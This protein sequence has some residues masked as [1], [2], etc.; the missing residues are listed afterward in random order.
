MT[1]Y[2]IIN[3]FV[4]NEEKGFRRT[5]SRTGSDFQVTSFPE[6]V[7][8]RS[9]EE[10]RKQNFAR[11]NLLVEEITFGQ[12]FNSNDVDSDELTTLYLDKI[13][14]MKLIL[15]G[16]LLYAPKNNV[17][18]NKC[19]PNCIATRIHFSDSSVKSLRDL[20]SPIL[21][22]TVSEINLLSEAIVITVYDGYS[23]WCIPGKNI[24]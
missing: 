21:A 10:R 11:Y 19:Q 24:P 6:L 9:L 13:A 15:P 12:I 17:F 4:D 22:L 16:N 23:S 14:A 20:Y 3:S 7:T 2:E 18:D 1:L 8:C 5:S